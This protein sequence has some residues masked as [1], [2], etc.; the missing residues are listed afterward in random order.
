VG[1][2][3]L[4]AFKSIEDFFD[5]EARR[6]MLDIHRPV[7][8]ALAPPIDSLPP[9]P[10]RAG[11][12]LD[13]LLWG[14]RMRYWAWRHDAVPG[15]KPQV[16]LFVLYFDPAARDTLPHSVGSERGMIGLVN[17]FA[18][19]EMTGTNAVVAAHE[20]LH[21]LGA[22]DKYDLATNLPHFPEGYAEPARSPRL[23][24]QFAEIM[25]GRVPLSETRAEIPT[26]LAVCVIGDATAAEIGWHRP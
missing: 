23:P 10:P 4:R 14:L 24:Q 18:S 3:Q 8:V 12:A 7:E 11:S 2:L 13:N 19:P 20:L 15:M 22:G 25:A 26:T 5:D 1:A 17:A 16:R 6:R 9:Q 21:T